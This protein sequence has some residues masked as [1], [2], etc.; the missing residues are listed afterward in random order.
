MTLALDTSVLIDI[1]NEVQETTKKLQQL[2]K[3][4]PGPAFVTY[5]PYFEFFSGLLN[6]NKKNFE[7]AYILL[8][9]FPYIIPTPDTA[10]IM[11]RMLKKYE[12]KGINFS[13]ADLMI[14][15]Q[16]K[17]HNLLLVTKDK[18]FEKIDEIKKVI[19]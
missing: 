15:S 14:A 13:L 19:L 3:S 18:D 10:E 8:Q 6:K 5:I 17:Q 4:H 12:K 16:V 7:R 9:K 2:R 11:A 1:E